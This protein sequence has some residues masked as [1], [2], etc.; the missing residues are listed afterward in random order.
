MNRRNFM[1]TIAGGMASAPAFLKAAG[2]RPNL[3]VVLCDDLGYGDL[4]CF[5]SPIVKTPHLDSFARQGMKFT[6]CYASAPVCSASR[7]GMLTGRTPDR[8]GVHD[9]IPENNVMHL[10]GNEITFARILR[11]AGYA[12]CHSGKW[13]CNGKF[14]SPD[15][16]QP[17]D[18][19]FDYWFSTQN[20]ALPTHENPVNF[21]RNGEP[22]GPLQG[23]SSTLIV[24]EAMRWLRS[25]DRR[26]PYCLFVCF[27]APHEPIATAPRFTDLY[28]AA[29]KRGEALY[30]GNVTQLDYEFGRLVSTIDDLGDGDDTFIMFTSD[31]GPETLNRYQG[32]WRSHGS[33]GPLRGM[34][35][36][37]WEGGYRVPGIVRWPKKVEA[38]QVSHEPICGVDVLPT[39]CELAGAEPP[40]GRPIDGASICPALEARPIERSVPLHWHYFNAMDRPKAS[41][42]DGD[43][44]IVGM[45]A[46]QYEQRVGGG[47][48]PEKSNLI[49][50][51]TLDSFE[52]YNLRRD[53]SEST[54]LSEQ[55]PKRLKTMAA[56]LTMLHEEVKAESPSWA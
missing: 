34:K 45:P 10:P 26:Q 35:L 33:P 3:V 9:W 25:L 48:E 16:P 30:Y 17:G 18:H 13:H 27:H 50:Q 53:L 51:L 1:T 23:Y 24:E 5:G 32:A 7:A 14:N 46:S 12:T 15:Q 31:N 41:L 38:G 44:K 8:C 6:D 19:G 39:L 40:T 54:D 11:S 20:N 49:K 42:R 36:T 52:L 2:R 37:M 47:F 4:N 22:A 28:P 56:K 21:V 43:W 55:E 29:R